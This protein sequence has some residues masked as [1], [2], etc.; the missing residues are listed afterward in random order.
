MGQPYLV[1]RASIN[2]DVLDKFQSWY[3]EVHLPHMLCIP[4][5]TGAFALRRAG[6]EN[7]YAALYPFADEKTLQKALTS[8]EAAQARQDWVPWMP[9]VSEITI[10]IYAKVAPLPSYQ[11][12]N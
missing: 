2:P 7:E 8:R 12:R 1:V 11:H 5:V 9:Y 3:H 4:G 10:E 6:H